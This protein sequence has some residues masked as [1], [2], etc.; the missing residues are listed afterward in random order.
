MWSGIPVWP[1]PARLCPY[2]TRGI[3]HGG[4]MQSNRTDR[5]ETPS[6]DWFALQLA[7][8]ER[9]A[10]ITGR[11]FAETML[12]FT[13]CYRRFGLGQARTPDHPIWQEYLRGLLLSADHADWTATFCHSHTQSLAV[14]FFGCFHYEYLAETQHIRLHF[15]NND[16]SGAGPLSRERLPHRHAELRALFMAIA[17]SLSAVRTVRGIS[18]LHGITAY[19]RLYPPEYGQSAR[20]VPAERV[21]ASMPLWGQFLDHA[22]QVKSDLAAVFLACLGQARTIADL[23]AC[24]PRQVYAVECDIEHFFHFYGVQFSGGSEVSAQKRQ[25]YDRNVYPMS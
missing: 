21:F 11:P 5:H 7:F 15:A 9:A 22:G 16:D 17:R 25:N 6:R 3:R 19:R 23:A 1:L 8:A 4:S 13:N 12:H 18:W 20:L 24:F 10:A 14:P 2:I